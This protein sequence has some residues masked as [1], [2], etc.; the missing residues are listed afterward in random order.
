[1]QHRPQMRLDLTVSGERMSG[2]FSV[3]RFQISVRLAGTVKRV[4]FCGFL[5]KR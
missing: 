3:F 4:P 5:R 2:E 1:M